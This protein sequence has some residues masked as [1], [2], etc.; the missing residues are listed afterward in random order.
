ML[1]TRSDIPMSCV[2]FWGLHVCFMAGFLL[3]VGF[4]VGAGG[5]N[6]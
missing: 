2:G 5:S 1:E 3:F 4:Y 6:L